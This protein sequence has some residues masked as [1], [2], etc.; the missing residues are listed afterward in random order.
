[1]QFYFSQTVKTRILHRN[2]MPLT[3]Y[4]DSCA[5]DWIQSLFFRFKALFILFQVFF[6]RLKTL[7]M[8]WFDKKN[9]KSTRQ[10]SISPRFKSHLSIC[11]MSGSCLA[12]VY[13]CHCP[14][15]KYSVLELWSLLWTVRILKTRLLVSQTDHPIR[16]F[17]SN[18][19]SI[20]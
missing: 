20:I 12:I 8:H 13:S 9:P 2:I 7:N 16:N 3:E 15:S 4:K 18:V 11:N 6:F 10:T 17:K 5:W 14:L 1:M 19:F